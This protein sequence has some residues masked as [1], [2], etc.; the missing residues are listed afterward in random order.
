MIQMVESSPV[1]VVFCIFCFCFFLFARGHCL[2]SEGHLQPNSAFPV[3]T[4]LFWGKTASLILIF[5]SKVTKQPFKRNASVHP[6]LLT[7]FIVAFDCQKCVFR[8][9]EIAS[10]W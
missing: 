6:S 7:N 5:P 8:L 10:A 1:A 3:I 4:Q 9:A 2:C